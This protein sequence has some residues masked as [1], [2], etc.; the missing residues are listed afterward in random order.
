MAL[1]FTRGR[2][3]ERIIKLNSI[4]FPTDFSHYNDEALEYASTLAAEANATLHIVHVHDV[5]DMNAAIGEAGI[6]YNEAWKR[7]NS[8]SRERLGEIVPTV[9]GVEY[10]HHYLTGAPGSAIVD[11]A[12]DNDIDLI[13]MA[14][15]GRSGISRLL[16]GSIAEN[17]LR[18]AP[19]PVLIV[20]Q[21]TA[22]TDSIPDAEVHSTDVRFS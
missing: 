8:I 20:K 6:L 18:K 14:S 15:H 7:E 19:C 9:A 17:V 4:L 5:N 2:T 10:K 3:Q 16:M 1:C 12:A 22:I 13:V 11:F 21:P